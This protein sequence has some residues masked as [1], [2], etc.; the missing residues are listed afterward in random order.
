MCQHQ[1]R[2]RCFPGQDAGRWGNVPGS[3]PDLVR[4]AVV[5]GGLAGLT[6]THELVRR[7]RI[8][9]LPLEIRLYEAEERFGGAIRS[10]RSQDFLCEH[11]AASFSTTDDGVLR[12]V[13][14]LGLQGELIAAHAE[15]GVSI[16]WNNAWH[17]MPPGLSRGTDNGRRAL[18]RNTLLSSRA[19]LRVALEAQVPIR[20]RSVHETVAGFV[21]RRFGRQMLER[22][23]EPLL[24]A[25]HYGDPAA[26]SVSYAFPEL[27][28][29]ERSHGSVRKG[30]RRLDQRDEDRF[31]IP[32]KIVRSPEASFRDGMQVLVD[33]VAAAVRRGDTG[34]LQCG[35]R[36]VGIRPAGDPLGA[37]AYALEIEGGEPWIADVCV[38]AV[39]A[40]VTARLVR[41]F[42]PEVADGLDAIPHSSSLAVSLGY[43][44]AAGAG[45]PEAMC[46]LVPGIQGRVALSCE[47]V[48]QEFDYRTPAGAALVRV[49]MGGA[50]NPALVDWDDDTAVRAARKEV[51]ELFGVRAEPVLA[52]VARR[53]RGHPQHLVDHAARVRA[54]EHELE[55][56]SGLLLTGAAIHGSSMAQVIDGSRATAATV[57]DMARSLLA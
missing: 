41:S 8:D 52:K 5:G 51:A 27:V 1:G 21:T 46:C 35:G 24:A 44:R 40:R 42:A 34:A 29:L 7:A 9:F 25:R 49:H 53:P 11:G 38:L 3:T 48:H 19:K 54:I 31:G 23:G 26:L 50:R 36:L 10:E 43:D 37:A 39:P 2:S 15:R 12:L 45:F 20:R 32:K 28:A 4:V 47:L 18:L 30:L 6:V 57:A 14:E 33:G 55:F 17:P 56:H 16:W 13:A 22:V